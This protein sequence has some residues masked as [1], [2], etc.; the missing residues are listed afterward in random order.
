MLCF[1]FNLQPIVAQVYHDLALY[2]E[3]IV[4]YAKHQVNVTLVNA[5]TIVRNVY[6]HNC[7]TIFIDKQ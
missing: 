7:C 6:W 1:Y 2:I 3:I 5:A 4:K